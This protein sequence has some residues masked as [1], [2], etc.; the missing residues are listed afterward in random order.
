MPILD[1]TMLLEEITKRLNDYVPA[2]TVSRIIED[3]TEVMRGFD[4][5]TLTAGEDKDG[6]DLVRLFL[7]A[8]AIE[9]RSQ[10]TINLYQ[11]HLKHLQAA[12]DVPLKN[13]TVYHLR[14]YLMA[15]KD[16]GLSPATIETKR[17]TFSAFFGWLHAEGLIQRNPTTNLA[18]V[19]QPK[20][21]RRPF[22]PVEIERLRDNAKTPRDIALIE[23]LLSTGCRVSEIC[24]VNRDDL[25]L[26]SMKLTVTGKGNK[27]RTVYIDEVTA[28]RVKA[29]LKTRTDFSPALFVGKGSDRLTPCGIR[30]ILNEIAS[31]AGV[32]NCHPHRFRRTLATNLIDHGMSVQEVAAV[33]GHDKLDTTMRY[34][35]V[36]Q[37][38]V[39][40]AYRRYA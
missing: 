26:R 25:D 12:I 24:S 27:Q 15:E 11:T 17:S 9:G 36:N 10:G 16:R 37:R 3:A 6:E 19:K 18:T 40:T 29:Y 32:E 23:T 8:K 13:V 5:V 21:V 20:E 35:Y 30:Y 31:R 2:N 1:K 34:V 4:V 22:S 33:L 39:E 7:E 38:N 14:S 28:M